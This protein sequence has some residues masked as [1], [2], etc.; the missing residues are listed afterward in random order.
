MPG[1][2][3]QSLD[4]YPRHTPG[5]AFLAQAAAQGGYYAIIGTDRHADQRSPAQYALSDAR[6]VQ[7][8]NAVVRGGQLPSVAWVEM[9]QPLK[10]RSKWEIPQ[11]WRMSA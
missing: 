10:Q 4:G 11:S 9:H 6:M 1:S 5:H 7:L 3:D 8:V 2:P